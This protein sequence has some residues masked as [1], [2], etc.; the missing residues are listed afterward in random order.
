MPARLQEA[1][2]GPTPGLQTRLSEAKG[3]ARLPFGL[4]RPTAKRWGV[5][6]GECRGDSAGLRRSTRYDIDHD[7]EHR[8]FEQRHDDIDHIHDHNDPSRLLGAAQRHALQRR[9]RLHEQR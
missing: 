6:Q 2:R 4:P 3:R 8:A 1:V 7:F 5:V 9:Q